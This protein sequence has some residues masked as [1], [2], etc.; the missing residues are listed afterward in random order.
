VDDRGFA[1]IGLHGANAA[2]GWLLVKSA[3]LPEQRRQ[4]LNFCTQ[5]A[6]SLHLCSAAYAASGINNPG[7]NRTFSGTYLVKCDVG[8]RLSLGGD[9]A[10]GHPLG[11][12]ALLLAAQPQVAHPVRARHRQPDTVLSQLDVHVRHHLAAYAILS[13]LYFALI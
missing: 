8:Q 9:A 5:F 1:P 4:R 2:S 13:N 11:V 12:L 7:I 3:A 10:G 6:A